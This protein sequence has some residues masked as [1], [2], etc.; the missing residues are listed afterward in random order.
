MTDRAVLAVL[1]DSWGQSV[2]RD[3]DGSQWRVKGRCD[4]SRCGAVCCKVADWRGLVGFQCEYLR[5]DLKC[6]PH[7]ERGPATKP[8]SCL[9]W[10]LR[11]LDVDSIN[12]KAE[13]LGFSE[14]CHLEVV[15]WQP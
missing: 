8:A 14:R 10:P 3:R 12:A 4:T 15:P 11:Q 13:R 7:A 2:F 9:F 6:R 1:T 5:P